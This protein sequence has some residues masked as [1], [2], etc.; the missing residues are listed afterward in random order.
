MCTGPVSIPAPAPQLPLVTTTTAVAVSPD[1]PGA[2]AAATV[3]AAVPVMPA[4]ADAA[5]AAAPVRPAAL[6]VARCATWALRMPAVSG[7]ASTAPGSISAATA[8]AVV[9]I[10]PDALAAA[11][12][13]CLRRGC[14]PSRAS[15]L[16][17]AAGCPV[18]AFVALGCIAARPPARSCVPAVAGVVPAAVPAGTASAS[19]Q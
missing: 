12:R 15:C 11:P 2:A 9:T 19:G 1:P 18:A 17:A 14:L 16:N 10:K 3:S 6:P 7:F 8:A 13:S 5:P 4:A